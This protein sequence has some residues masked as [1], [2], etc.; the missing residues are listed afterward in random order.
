MAFAADTA[1]G[2]YRPAASSIEFCSNGARGPQITGQTFGPVSIDRNMEGQ[3]GEFGEGGWRG[4]KVAA[5]GSDAHGVQELGRTW[6]EME[7]YEGALDF[8]EKLGRARHV[9]TDLSGSR[10]RA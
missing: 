8:L 3:L 2:W 7:P 4:R 5:I 1:T 6:M 10:R 9:M